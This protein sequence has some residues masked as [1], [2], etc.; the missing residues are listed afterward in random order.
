MGKARSSKENEIRQRQRER[1]QA[2]DELS[3][4][5]EGL[6]MAVSFVRSCADRYV[7]T[8]QAHAMAEELER[9]LPVQLPVEDNEDGGES[10]ASVL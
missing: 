5:R 7:S 3:K 10:E 6:A 4:A 2:A 9:M 1:A 8:D